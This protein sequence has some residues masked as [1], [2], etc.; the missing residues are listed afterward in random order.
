LPILPAS[1]TRPPPSNIASDFAAGRGR[2]WWV[3][4]ERLIA[5]N[6][7][8]T[9]AIDGDDQHFETATVEGKHAAFARLNGW[10]VCAGRR[11]RRRTGGRRMD[12]PATAST[13][14]AQQHELC[15]SWDEL[16]AFAADPLITI[17]ATP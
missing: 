7:R 8:I 13:A 14:T 6:D 2:L 1:S 12:A 10:V 3:A 9:V 5:A 17:G 16:R 4:L 11:P 15:M